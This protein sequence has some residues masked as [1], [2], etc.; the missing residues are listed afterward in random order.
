MT[1][2]EINGSIKTLR[3]SGN[4]STMEFCYNACWLEILTH[5]QNRV[6]NVG[7]YGKS[8]F[9]NVSCV[10]KKTEKSNDQR[11]RIV[12]SFNQK[13]LDI[14][15]LLPHIAHHD[16]CLLSFPS[17]SCIFPHLFLF[18]FASSPLLRHER[19]ISQANA[20]EDVH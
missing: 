18:Q 8:R 15:C 17:P 5:L 3:P 11:D 4:D 19:S 10:K 6:S 9:A 7:Q 12:S 13:I 14:T 20:F 1:V 2:G 16:S